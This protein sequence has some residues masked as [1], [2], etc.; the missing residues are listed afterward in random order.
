MTFRLLSRRL[1]VS[2]PQNAAFLRT[3]IMPPDRKLTKGDISRSAE[4]PNFVKPLVLRLLQGPMT[5]R[6]AYKFFDK[7]WKMIDYVTA[8][9]KWARERYGEDAI[10]KRSL[11]GKRLPKGFWVMSLNNKIFDVEKKKVNLNGEV[12][13]G[14]IVMPRV[15]KVIMAIAEKSWVTGEELEALG[16]KKIDGINKQATDKGF[17]PVI[18]ATR[19][20]PKIYMVNPKFARKFK[21]QTNCRIELSK[22]FSIP[23][24]ALINYL[25]DNGE[26]RLNDLMK[27]HGTR[28][29]SAVLA[30]FARINERCKELGLSEAIERRGSRNIRTFGLSRNFCEETK[31]AEKQSNELKTYFTTV[32][33]TVIEDM[34][35]HP[36]AR[37]SEIGARLSIVKHGVEEHLRNIKRICEE[38]N[39]PHL[40][41]I[42]KGRSRYRLD[43]EFHT[44]FDLKEVKIN[45][46]NCLYGKKQKRIFEYFIKTHNKTRAEAAKALKMSVDRVTAQIA[47]INKILQQARLPTIEPAER[48]IPRVFN[49]FAEYAA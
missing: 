43:R 40:I 19:T 29:Y 37:S 10:I 21:I 25:A 33:I 9:N 18:I 22:M 11:N 45:P 44:R 13:L 32:Q 12:S 28:H 31:M 14:D 16:I 1:D 17:P 23:G 2:M 34:R 35:T 15:K 38:N 7:E 3:T 20:W 48:Y 41:K 24:L 8:A 49:P 46:V 6:E 26:M 27:K 42:G 36:F 47:H 30:Q 39:L 4:L 5:Q